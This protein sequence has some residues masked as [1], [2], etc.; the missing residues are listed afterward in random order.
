MLARVRDHRLRHAGQ[1]RDVQTETAAR[2]ALLDRVHEHE[3]VVVLD[4]VEVHVGDARILR[5]QFGQLEVMRREQSEGMVLRR[6]LH[7]AGLGEGETVVGRGAAAD[8]VHQHEAVPRRVVQDIRR[9]AHLDHEGRLAARQIIARADAREDAVD[10]SHFCSVRGDEAADMREQ[11]DQR[12]LAHVGRL[13]AHVRAGDDQHA[14]VV[15]E[16]EIVRFE[17]I[18][19][20]LFDDRMTAAFDVY[21]F[22]VHEPRRAPVQR[23][24]TVGERGE[25]VEFGDRSGSLFE[26]GEALDEKIEQRFVQRAL[27]HQRTFARGQ[28]LVLE[29]F[30]LFGDVA[31]GAFQRL[32]ARV[33]RWRLVGLAFAD[34]DVVAVH[35]VVADLERGDARGGFLAF[36]QIDEELVR[37]GRQRTQLVEFGVVAGRDHAA[38]A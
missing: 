28:H 31:F 9:L 22:R 30:Q 20:H 21:P 36:F 7:G 37:V 29:R 11:H 14:A 3:L 17:R 25:H 35:A 26:R 32:P 5:G 2:R 13:T 1:R 12:V 23:V 10:R 15:V 18:A 6:Q 33:V 34:F 4:R 24:G 16:H 38:V 19:A 27:A 8:F